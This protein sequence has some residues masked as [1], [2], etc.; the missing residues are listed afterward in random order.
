MNKKLSSLLQYVFFLGLGI[1]LVWWSIG[2]IEAKDWNEMKD[3]L[4]NARYWLVLPVALALLVS[5]YSRAIRWKILMEPMGY[6]PSTLN[7]YFAVLIGYMAN[8]AVPRLGEVLKCTILARYE[9]V[10]ADKLVGTIVAERAFDLICL[11]IVF[12]I[13]IFSQIDII[14]QFA[15]E[16]LEKLLGG[17]K[18]QFQP[19]RIGI[20]LLTIAALFFIARYLLKRLSHIGFIQK[21]KAIFRGIL[22]GLTSVRYVKKKGWFFFHTLLIWFLYLA[23]IRIGFYAMEPTSGYGWLPSFS[24]LALGSV[25]MIVTQGGIGAYPILVQETMLL[26]GLNENIGKAFGWLLWLVQFFLVMIA[27]GAALLLLPIINRKTVKGTTPQS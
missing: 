14:G 2:K 7:T 12:F 1:F 26:Y 23:S 11:V 24:V 10:P 5:H 22:E 4:R 27:G 20:F 21:L 18:G 17:S 15:G 13:T 3:A 9:K 8:L 25:G 16:I 6:R 19:M